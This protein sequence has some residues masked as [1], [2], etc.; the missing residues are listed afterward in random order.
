MMRGEEPDYALLAAGFEN[1]DN[2]LFY[3]LDSCWGPATGRGLMLNSWDELGRNINQQIPLGD[4]F[5]QTVDEIDFSRYDTMRNPLNTKTV[6]YNRICR[7]N[8]PQ[9]ED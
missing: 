1:D 3:E 4:V 6:N 2:Q 7:C 9:P 8:I 5:P